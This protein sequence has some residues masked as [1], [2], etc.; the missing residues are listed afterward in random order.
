MI[1]R[2][3]IAGSALA[4]LWSCQIAAAPAGAGRLSKAQV[5]SLVGAMETATKNGDPRTVTSFMADDCVITTTFPAREGGSK[6]SVK[7]KQKFL[8]DEAAAAR[9]HTNRAYV[10]TPPAIDIDA[11]GR[12]AK[13]SYKAT[14]TYVQDG[15]KVQVT[16]YEIATVELRGGEPVVTAIDVDA[17]AMTIDDR[18]IF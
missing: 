15:R 2:G 14:E 1:R 9:K 4:L 8:A 12:F 18:R 16:G 7:D 6:V 13:A 17:V 5:E 3:L 11:A 10:S